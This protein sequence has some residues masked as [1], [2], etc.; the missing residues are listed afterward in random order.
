MWSSQLPRSLYILTN[1]FPSHARQ[2]SASL[3]PS[4]SSST[5]TEK[6]LCS[7]AH[8]SY[9]SP[10]QAPAS[11]C[12]G[13]LSALSV[14][15]HGVKVLR[16]AFAVR[17]ARGRE[18]EPHSTRLVLPLLD[19]PEPLRHH[20]RLHVIKAKARSARFVEVTWKHERRP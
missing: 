10:L 2:H 12:S 3:I 19:R 14:Q 11:H 6:W 20:R 16:N 8:A 17:R 5:K 4:P 9:L 13:C 1:A 15:L 7:S 18:Y